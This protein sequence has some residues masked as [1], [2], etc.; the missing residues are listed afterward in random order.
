MLDLLVVGPTDSPRREKYR[1]APADAAAR[2]TLLRVA[3]CESGR[4]EVSLDCMPL[5]DYGRIQGEWRYEGDSYDRLRVTGAGLSLSLASSLRLGVTEARAYGRTHLDAGAAAFVALSWDGDP[6][7][8][9]DGALAQL[10]ET[11]AFWRDWLSAAQIPDHRYRPYIERSTLTLKGLSYAPTG[12]IMAAG[13]TSLPETPGGER[14]WDYRYTW[15]RDSAFLLRTLHGLG[16]DWEAFE[17]FAFL[18]DAIEREVAE[19][20]AVTFDLQIMYGISGERDLTEQSL[21]HLSGYIGS[22]PVRIGN[23]AYDQHQH[24]VW[25]MLLDSVATHVRHGGQL[26]PAVWSGLSGL[27]DAAVTR[28]PE[29]DQGIWEMRGA[30]KH[31]VASKVMCWVAVDRGVRLATARDDHD[32]AQRWKEAADKMHA[33]IL[34]RGVAPD[35][36]F[37]QHYDTDD[38]D[39]SLLLIPMMGFLPPDDERVRAHRP[40]NR[41]PPHQR[42]SRT[43]LPRRDHRRRPVRRGGDVHDLLLLARRGARDDRRSRPRPRLVREAALV[44]RSAPALRRRDRHDHGPAS[45]QLP[46][47]V[48][49]PLTHRRRAAAHREGGSEIG[50]AG[51]EAH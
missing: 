19:D 39:A 11:K 5:F 46:A 48:H 9:V 30:P 49:A 4:V 20:G 17:Y 7:T 22:R 15:I 40:R 2:G 26:A 35:G 41:R 37:K 18:L 24:D 3:M 43:A 6:P 33:E 28:F 51:D 10:E 25:G 47:G 12:A 13:T 23:G 34:E 36:V 16:F 14:N 21:D 29:P 50:R 27:V 32:R 8:S 1:R 38:L 45:R 31:F 42:R 44:R